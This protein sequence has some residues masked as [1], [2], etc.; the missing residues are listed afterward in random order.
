MTPKPEVNP[1]GHGQQTITAVVYLEAPDEH[2][3]G[4]YYTPYAQSISTGASDAVC[5]FCSTRLETI[6]AQYFGRIMRELEHMRNARAMQTT[7][8]I[9]LLPLTHEALSCPK[10][11]MVLTRPLERSGNLVGQESVDA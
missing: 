8:V 3:E 1:P 4:H 10:C 7:A 2:V 9:D 11:D 5:P 6:D